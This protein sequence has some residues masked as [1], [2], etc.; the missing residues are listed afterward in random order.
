MSFWGGFRRVWWWFWR[1]CR[2]L[3]EGGRKGGGAEELQ[4][5]RRI[6]GG[7]KRGGVPKQS[8]RAAAAG[9]RAGEAR[10]PQLH[11]PHIEA[12]VRQVVGQRH[13][14]RQVKGVGAGG[15]EARAEDDGMVPPRRGSA[16]R[17]R[18]GVLRPHQVQLP[19]V[20]RR[21]E[22]VALE[23]AAPG[24]AVGGPAGRQR[25]RPRA[26]ASSR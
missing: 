3:R 12:A 11:D 2:G 16:A 7:E 25:R 20:S 9:G 5:R 18:R 22:V 15:A 10:T 23:V 13:D 21:A 1:G 4:R 26:S 14:G 19:V 17:R 24:A 6:G 8:V